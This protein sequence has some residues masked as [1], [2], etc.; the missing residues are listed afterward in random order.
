MPQ[1]YA[2]PSVLEPADSVP[3]DSAIG[4]PL[5]NR[6]RFVYL[7]A[8]PGATGFY[9]VRPVAEDVERIRSNRMVPLSAARAYRVALRSDKLSHND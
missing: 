2:E 9:W 5:V 4:V 3:L 1:S 8:D 6:L 7:V